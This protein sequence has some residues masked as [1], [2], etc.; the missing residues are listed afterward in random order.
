M[1]FHVT[2]IQYVEPTVYFLWMMAR[3]LKSALVLQLG[4]YSNKIIGYFANGV[5]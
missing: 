1:S 5:K 4:Q 3:Y 2:E